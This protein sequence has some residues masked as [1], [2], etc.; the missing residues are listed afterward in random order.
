MSE[1]HCTVQWD[2]TSWKLSGTKSHHH[3]PATVLTA[4]IV[5]AQTS[6]RPSSFQ[7]ASSSWASCRCAAD[8][9]MGDRLLEIMASD[10][11]AYAAELYMVPDVTGFMIMTEMCHVP[12]DSWF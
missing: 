11:C 3:M 12:D 5:V 8:V 10:A 4:T 9:A 1:A 2:M 7:L 6:V